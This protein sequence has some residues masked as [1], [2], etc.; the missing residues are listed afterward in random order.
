VEREGATK[1]RAYRKADAIDHRVQ[2]F[3][4]Q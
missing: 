2:V 4:Y 3:I 1:L